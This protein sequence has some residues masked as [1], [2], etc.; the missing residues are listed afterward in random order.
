MKKIASILVLLCSILCF[1]VLQGCINDNSNPKLEDG[2][3]F[4]PILGDLIEHPIS[5]E[6]HDFVFPFLNSNYYPV[7]LITEHTLP[8]NHFVTE[9]PSY[10]NEGIIDSVW[11]PLPDDYYTGDELINLWDGKVAT[12]AMRQSGATIT[13][14]LYDI[15]YRWVHVTFDNEK[16]MVHVDA[17]DTDEQRC[18]YVVCDRREILWSNVIS[19][20]QRAKE[21]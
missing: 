6:A 4:G 19:I 11:F 8:E 12:D 1:G 7:V 13:Q 17:N 21:H 9:N 18:V 2:D 3:P 10:Q 15:V 14:E 16:V 20:V 5:S